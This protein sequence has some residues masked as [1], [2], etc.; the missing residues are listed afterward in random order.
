MRQSLRLNGYAMRQSPVFVVALAVLTACNILFMQVPATAAALQGAKNIFDWLFGDISTLFCACGICAGFAVCG[1]LKNGL[2]RYLVAAGQNRGM[3]LTGRYLCWLF[4]AFCL[5]L[6]DF[7]V[8][9]VVAVP[10]EGCDFP[11]PSLAAHLLVTF[12]PAI[13]LYA[14]VLSLFFLAGVLLQNGG[15]TIAVNILLSL[16]AYASTRGAAIRF[17]PM[18]QLLALPQGLRD[19]VG[20]GVA[21]LL[22]L[23]LCAASLS[24]SL[25]RF[26]RQPLAGKGE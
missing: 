4:A 3:W 19:P 20:Y 18:E 21:C 23:L 11:L 5:L 25:L 15:I 8:A 17:N 6:T 2:A 16:L 13:P 7:V 22:S 9:T 12:L 1:D 14:G 10:L 24:G 26:A